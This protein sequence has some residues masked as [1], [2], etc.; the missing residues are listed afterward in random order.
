MEQAVSGKAVAGALDQ[1]GNAVL[2][3]SGHDTNL[4][5]ISGMLGLS[6]KLPGYQPDDTPPGGALIFSLWQDA[7][8]RYTV[9]TQYIAQSLDQMRNN[10]PLTTSAP[11]L[12]QDVVIP[13]CRSGKGSP[14]CEW[15]EFERALQKAID[16]GFTSF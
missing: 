16:S 8:G 13:G 5:N 11:P 9:T 4:S 1:P 10:S 3:L 12:K 7:G 14:S 15:S 2:I 6:W